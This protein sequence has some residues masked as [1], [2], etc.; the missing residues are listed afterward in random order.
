MVS[1]PRQPRLRVDED[2]V[3]IVR[4]SGGPR[5]IALVA[6]AVA[7]PVLATLGAIAVIRLAPAGSDPVEPARAAVGESTV[8]TRDDAGPAAPERERVRPAEA[9]R[10]VRPRRIVRAEA[11]PRPAQHPK[12]TEGEGKEALP[13]VDA[14]DVILA[15]REQGDHGGIA[16]FGLPGTDP[17][18]PG[19][20]VPEDFALPEGFVRHYQVTD[21]GTRL[22]A[23]LMVHPDYELVDAGGARVEV[24][25]RIVPPELA[26]AGLPIHMLEVP[27]GAGAADRTP[28]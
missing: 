20:I 5:T 7:L 25:D 21:D 3:R 27:Q 2:G 26:P 13:E 18:K 12:P 16:A 24:A 1:Q 15:L 14:R 9:E 8:G 23:I 28:Q 19:I 4:T 11:P 10:D 22:P 6:L 17:V